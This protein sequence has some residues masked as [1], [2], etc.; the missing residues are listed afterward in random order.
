MDRRRRPTGD[1]VPPTTALPPSLLLNLQVHAS[2]TSNPTTASCKA[3]GGDDVQVTLFAAS[4]HGVSR[5]QLCCSTG[6]APYI[7]ATEA[8]LVLLGVAFG[9]NPARSRS[10]YDYFVYR[11][12]AGEGASSLELLPDPALSLDDSQVGILRRR[13]DGCYF[14]AALCYPSSPGKYDLRLYSS[15][16]REWTT[17]QASLDQQQRVDFCHVNRKIITVRGESGTMAWVDLWHG[18]LLCDV[19]DEEPRIRY[20]LLPPP[21]L[22]TRELE[23]CPRN[24][25][26]IAVIHQLRR[27]ADPHRARFIEHRQLHLRWLD[28]CCMEHRRYQSSWRQGLLAPGLQARCFSGHRRSR[29]SSPF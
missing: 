13:G 22:P 26:D 25:R 7:V 28:R 21:L 3:T 27:A 16:T 11:L 29:Q 10:R 6:S 4:P 20:I 24:A 14:V 12:G 9:P 2:P 8:D 15:T 5:L 1:G 18:M 23:G 17:K 19:L